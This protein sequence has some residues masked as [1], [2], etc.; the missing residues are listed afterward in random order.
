[1][2]R[3][4]LDQFIEGL[5]ADAYRRG[6]NAAVGEMQKLLSSMGSAVAP[7]PSDGAGPR[8][9]SDQ[10]L[11]LRTIQQRPGH[12]GVDIVQFLEG[13]VQER[14]IRTALHRLKRKGLIQKIGDRWFAPAGEET[15]NEKED[16]PMEG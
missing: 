9:G 4:Q 15:P 13:Q 10:E 12:R 1:M 2:D 8:R 14:T 3:A 6:Y 5:E 11:V 7:S 16:Q